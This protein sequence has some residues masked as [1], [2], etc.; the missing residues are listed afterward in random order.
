[1]G[2][3]PW[4][5]KLTFS[6]FP[7]PNSPLPITNYQLPITNIGVGSSISL[8]VTGCVIGTVDQSTHFTVRLLNAV[9]E[10][11]INSKPMGTH[12]Y[13]VSNPRDER[14]SREPI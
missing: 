1:M 5:N 6:Q 9:K 14:I 10:N 11:F 2:H 4:C 13:A 12:A 8:T 3:G 7:I